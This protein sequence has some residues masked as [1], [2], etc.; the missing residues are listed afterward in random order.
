M[1]TPY[2]TY[3]QGMFKYT[4]PETT[5]DGKVSMYWKKN[6]QI[7]FNASLSYKKTFRE[8]HNFSALA[9]VQLETLT[10]QSLSG[11][12]EGFF[13]PGYDDMGNGSKNQT[14]ASALD[15]W[16]MLSYYGVF[17]YNY[18]E[19]YLIELTGR[20]DGSSRFTPD[21]RWGFF[22]GGSVAYRIS[23]EPFWKPVEKYVSSLKI[24]ASYAHFGNQWL[25]DYYP[26][27]SQMVTNLWNGYFFNG[28]QLLGSIQS[29]LFNADITWETS[30][31]T[32]VGLDVGFLSDKLTLTFDFFNRDISDLIQIPPIP[33]YV[34]Y[35]APYFNI[36]K[37]RARGY[38]IS[39]TY[40][41]SS[42][43]GNWRYSFTANFSDA[44]STILEV[45]DIASSNDL[46]A[47]RPGEL[48]NAIRGWKTDGF[49]RDQADIDASP[50]F[51]DDKTNLKPGDVKYHD[52]DGNGSI[53]YNDV[54]VLGDASPRYLYSLTA[55][56]SWKNFRPLGLHPGRRR[57]DEALQRRRHH[58]VRQRTLDVR[59]PDRLLARG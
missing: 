11:S 22:P 24:R 16:A 20:L 1:T 51:N 33:T 2:D 41:N 55:N 40:R 9:G 52:K 46:S 25:N 15:E 53:D 31:Q 35:D 3:T 54:Y 18:K 39:L 5:P 37:M 59:E 14:S 6:Q 12:R 4:Y 50:A 27:T 42:K 30:K 17:N 26:F 38:D 36:G 56:V 8:D 19:K 10:S 28:G 45:A 29:K 58:P 23:Q 34:V 44:K 7:Q 57:A 48:R 13:I 43:N 49:Y 32:N 47:L 21:N